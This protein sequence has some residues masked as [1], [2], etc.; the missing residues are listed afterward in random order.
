MRA[1]SFSLF[2]AALVA[3]GYALADSAADSIEKRDARM[4]N[5]MESVGE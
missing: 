3:C 4:A 1:L 5:V 2:F